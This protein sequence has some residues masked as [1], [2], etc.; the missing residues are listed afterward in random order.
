MKEKKIQPAAV[1]L[2]LQNVQKVHRIESNEID[3]NVVSKHLEL[4]R[5]I[6]L[7][8]CAFLLRL[9]FG[10]V[11]T[12]TTAHTHTNTNTHTKKKLHLIEMNRH[13]VIYNYR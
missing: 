2:F 6:A 12:F 9:V 11:S 1:S 10:C 5:L 13:I 8:P 4:H 7:Y 3:G